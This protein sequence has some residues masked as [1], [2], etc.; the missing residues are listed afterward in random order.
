MVCLPPPLIIKVKQNTACFYLIEF[1][2]LIVLFQT[3]C[4]YSLDSFTLIVVFQT[5]C[6]RK[7]LKRVW[8]CN[9]DP[10]K[11]GLMQNANACIWGPS[12]NNGTPNQL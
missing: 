8:K 5:K 1:V 7:D 6:V 4:F 9:L 11:K 12:Q 2:N 10:D 3:K